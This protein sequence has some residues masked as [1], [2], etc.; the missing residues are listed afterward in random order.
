MA[1]SAI[2]LTNPILPVT[3][4]NPQSSTPILSFTLAKGT[5]DIEYFVTM[6]ANGG[7]VALF[8]SAN[9]LIANSEISGHRSATATTATGRIFL[10]NAGPAATTI[11]IKGWGSSAFQVLSDGN[12]GRTGVAFTDVI[13]VGVGPQGPAGKDGT[14]GAPGIQGPKGNDGATGPAGPQGLPG[15]AG[16]NGATGATGAKG[17]IG[18][19]GVQGPQ[20]PGR[21]VTI[22]TRAP[23]SADGNVGDIWYQIS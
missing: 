14:P 12:N 7:Q 18:P 6:G 13:T 17:D 20:G 9:N 15:L 11:K 5:W 21:P 8:D 1:A 2:Y 19:A 23:T 10:T 4:M 16:K 22:N 3:G